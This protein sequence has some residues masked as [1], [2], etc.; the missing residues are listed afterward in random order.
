MD[1]R[2]A[3][4]LR[5]GVRRCAIVPGEHDH[6]YALG[7]EHAMASGL[8]SLMG[9]AMPS[10]PARRPFVRDV[11]NGMPLVPGASACAACGETYI[12]VP[13]EEAVA[14]RHGLPATRPH[15]FATSVSKPATSSARC[16]ARGRVHTR[17]G[18]A[19]ACSRVQRGGQ[20]HD[21]VFI[22]TGQRDHAHQLGLPTVIVPV[23]SSTSVSTSRRVS[24]A[25]ASL[26]QD[27]PRSRRGPRR[28]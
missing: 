28:P 23:L 25:C 18:K 12:P 10:I 6:A 24:S 19:D 27:A 11:D 16:F 21:F 4:L 20:P 13:H 26:K 3:Q 2:D 7:L 15:A 9:S 14:Y 22:G 17:P 8:V 1:F 5:N